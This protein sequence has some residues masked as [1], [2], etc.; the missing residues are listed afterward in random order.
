[1]KK[2]ITLIILALVI[3]LLPPST[4][5]ALGD[6]GGEILLAKLFIEDDTRYG[7]KVITEKED[8]FTSS[9]DEKSS[10]SKGAVTALRKERAGINRDTLD[11]RLTSYVTAQRIPQNLRYK[12]PAIFPDGNRTKPFTSSTLDFEF[13][14]V[15]DGV[16]H[17]KVVQVGSAMMMSVFLHE[18]GHYIIADHLGA[19]GNRIKFL[20][21]SKD[22]GFSFGL[23][24][25]ERIDY[26]SQLPYYMGGEFAADLTFEY[27]LQSYRLRPTLYNKAL[28]FFSGTDFLRYSVYA[29][30]LSDGHS[31]F[32][33]INVSEVT[34][35][36]KETIF[37]AILAK[38]VL[39]AYRVYSG[40]DR[41]VPYFSI[42]K[43]SAIFNVKVV[44]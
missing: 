29:F 31:H 7:D 3:L 19:E 15:L 1:M 41:V 23:S 35:F 26:R 12:R 43:Y 40:Q 22:G 16:A 32:D 25:V 4:A 6:N 10:K 5:F 24:T 21:K 28:L 37:S 44:F 42:D 8:G 34:G 11:L 13:L 30:Y 33:P 17:G 2:D 18:M 27:A 20:K 36:S 39:N 14:S 38:T 9:L